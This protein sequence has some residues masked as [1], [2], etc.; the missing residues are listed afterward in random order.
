[1]LAVA[2]GGILDAPGGGL[3]QEQP[4]F[5]AVFRAV[6]AEHRRTWEV[7]QGTT[8][9]WTL[10]CTGDI[11][12]GART[13]E[14]RVLPDVLPEGGRRISVEDLADFLLREM[15]EGRWPRRRV[16]VGY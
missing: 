3:R 8:L 1:V 12:P 5:P 11:V 14:Y 16:G 15:H 9:A 4:Q 10:A 7:L 2:G 13:G 6:S